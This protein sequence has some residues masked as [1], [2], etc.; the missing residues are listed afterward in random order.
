MKLLYVTDSLF[1][2]GKNTCFSNNIFVLFNI[3]GRL[4][5]DFIM[6]RG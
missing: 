1:Y 3:E 6:T 2:K 4:T 5:K